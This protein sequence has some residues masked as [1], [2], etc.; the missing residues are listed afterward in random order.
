MVEGEHDWQGLREGG[1]E[2]GK[3][4]K[5]GRK[6]WPLVVVFQLGKGE[7]REGGREGGK[8]EET[9]GERVDKYVQGRRGWKSAD[10]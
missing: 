8:E 5:K 6:E 10:A 1:E 2:G 3:E 7:R 4:G 9:E